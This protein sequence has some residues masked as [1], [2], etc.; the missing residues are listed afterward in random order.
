MR[1][2][3]FLAALAFAGTALADA[4]FTITIK[5]HKFE[6]AELKVPANE[7]IRL[8]IVNEDDSAEEFESHELNR[9]KIVAPKG[10]IT[11]IVGPLEPG[12]YPFF[13]EFHM[14]TAQGALIAE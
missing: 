10:R 8:L 5:D 9:E 1:L 2:F 4:E 7:K 3:A 14:E 11:V 12:R 13:G 6:P